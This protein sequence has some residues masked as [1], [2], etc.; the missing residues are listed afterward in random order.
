MK[1]PTIIEETKD[2]LVLNKPAGLLVHPDGVSAKPTLVDWLAVRFPDIRGVGEPQRL[3][4]G[5]IIERPGIVHRLDY[6]TSG[7]LLVARTPEMYAHFK[8]QFQAHTIRKVYHAFCYGAMKEDFGI[9]QTPITR[10]ASDIRK[11]VSGRVGRGR[12]R[13]AETHFR[14]LSRFS[15]FERPF[16]Y[17]DLRPQ[18]GR[19]H[20]LRVHMQSLSRPLVM[21]KLYAGA[22]TDAEPT[23]GFVRVALHA[24]EITFT[25]LSGREH[26]RR[27]P[28]PEDF[29]VALKTFAHELFDQFALHTG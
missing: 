13:E 16:S 20:Q 15:A 10:S 5:E 19:T 14:T 25:D 24:L 6:E 7:V 29:T 28:L 1:G 4:S 18:T 12:V 27:A 3:R 2:Y 11:F 22:L 26:T 23:L 8:A 9:I 21:D 17:V